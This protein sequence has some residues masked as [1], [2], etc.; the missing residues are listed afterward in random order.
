[1]FFLRIVDIFAIKCNIMK[2]FNR[3]LIVFASVFALTACV[4]DKDNPSGEIDLRPGDKLPKF[5]VLMND[6]STIDR[7]Q[8]VGTPSLIVF[9][10]TECH[11]CQ[12]EFPVLQ[13]VYE[14][15][16]DKIK[17]VG[18]GTGDTAETLEKYWAEHGLT[19]P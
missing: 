8:L 4:N 17:F 2:L 15:Y 10:H 16:G 7:A 13:D 12:Q 18:I 3:I 6:G 1:M 11:D 19:F 5:S 14:S 9:F